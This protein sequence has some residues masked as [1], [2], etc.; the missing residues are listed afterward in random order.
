VSHPL[1]RRARRSREEQER[2]QSAHAVLTA[3]IESVFTVYGMSDSGNCYKVRLAL[4]ALPA[5]SAWLE[6]VRAQPRHVPM[7]A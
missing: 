5:L 6:R 3:R 2:D 7:A 4:P 1:H